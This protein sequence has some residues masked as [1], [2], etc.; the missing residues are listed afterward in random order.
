MRLAVLISAALHLAIVVSALPLLEQGN[1]LVSV[2]LSCLC[3]A[4]THTVYPSGVCSKA[5]RGGKKPKVSFLHGSVSEND[6]NQRTTIQ[7]AANH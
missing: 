4:I 1:D 5:A 2:P 7:N 6:S 3:C